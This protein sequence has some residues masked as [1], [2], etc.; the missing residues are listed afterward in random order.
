MALEE[1]VKHATQVVVNN[2]DVDEL[3]L[4]VRARL[5]CAHGAA[6]GSGT[7]RLVLK[8]P[9]GVHWDAR[10]GLAIFGVVW[11]KLDCTL[12]QHLSP[13]DIAADGR[14]DLRLRW[15]IA[16][17]VEIGPM[18]LRRPE[19]EGSPRSPPDR[20][21]HRRCSGSRGCTAEQGATHSVH[22]AGS[23]VAARCGGGLAH[24]PA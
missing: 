5:R 7:E 11:S 23:A 12:N 3:R 22:Q 19:P 18:P 1:K 17:D 8:P 4:Q 20:A 15:P 6:A 14:L 16:H 24:P 21:P 10:E 13:A 9:H 2:G